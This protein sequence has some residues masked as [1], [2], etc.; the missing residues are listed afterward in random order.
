[1][2]VATQRAHD[3][4]RPPHVLPQQREISG[5]ALKLLGA[6]MSAKVLDRVRDPADA[7]TATA[8]NS[9]RPRRFFDGQAQR[10]PP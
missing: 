1:M 4:D 6:E 2:R 9:W 7:T 10:S 5:E 3:H 8:D